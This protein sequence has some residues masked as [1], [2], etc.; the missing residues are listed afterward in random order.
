MTGRKLEGS[1]EFIDGSLENG[2]AQAASRLQ[3]GTAAKFDKKVRP[4]E[5]K[6]LQFGISQFD[7]RD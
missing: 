1:S 6:G 4:A 7:K 3:T 5:P 2:I